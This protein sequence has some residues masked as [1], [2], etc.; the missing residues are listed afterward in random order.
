MKKNEFKK[1]LREDNR[2]HILFLYMIG[3]IFL[4]NKQLDQVLSKK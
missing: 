2:H 4:T 3:K 1:I